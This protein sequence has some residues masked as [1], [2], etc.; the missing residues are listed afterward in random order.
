MLR[1]I[2]FFIFSSSFISLAQ[3]DLIDQS[4]YTYKVLN[5]ND[6][7]WITEDFKATNYLNGDEIP[8]VQDSLI[9]ANLTSGAWCYFN[10][11]STLGRLYNYFVFVDERGFIPDGW[12]LPTHNGD[13]NPLYP[14]SI[15]F[16]FLDDALKSK[17]CWEN[18][19]YYRAGRDGSYLT[20]HGLGLYWQ[21]N[22]CD[23]TL[24]IRR[25]EGYDGA[26]FVEVCDIDAFEEGY[27]EFKDQLE[28]K[29]HGFK[30]RLIKNQ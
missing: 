2:L 22:E 21:P 19:C 11:D 27:Y 24:Q 4:G 28:M 7:L 17:K 15:K 5:I 23:L 14:D 25:C 8:Q 1:T 3:G 12:R 10:N 18:L 30:I 13:L 26:Y 29:R 6:K 20:M 9:W 16:L